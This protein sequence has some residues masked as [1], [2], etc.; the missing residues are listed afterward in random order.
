MLGGVLRNVGR[1]A[2]RQRGV[3]AKEVGAE[4]LDAVAAPEATMP[5]D[6]CETLAPKERTWLEG[7]AS[8][9][10]DDD[11]AKAWGVHPATVSR[12]RSLLRKKINNLMK[13][14]R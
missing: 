2:K 4:F 11:L 13:T 3:R 5:Q 7:F 8:L 10:R 6:W 1:N 12:R 9:V 14:N